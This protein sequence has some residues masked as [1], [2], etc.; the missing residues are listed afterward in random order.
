MLTPSKPVKSCE[1]GSPCGDCCGCTK[2]SI[3]LGNVD[4]T[5]DLNKPLSTAM[6]NALSG[7]VDLDTFTQLKN[8]VLALEN[9]MPDITDLEHRMDEAEDDILGLNAGYNSLHNTILSMADS[10]TDLGGRVTGVSDEL[11]TVGTR[12]DALEVAD[13][14]NVKID[15]AQDI[16]SRKTFTIPPIL[17]GNNAVYEALYLKNENMESNLIDENSG[18]NT[19]IAYIAKDNSLQARLRFRT[20][21][22]K[23]RQ[24]YIDIVDNVNTVKS[25]CIAQIIGNG[26]IYSPMLDAYAPMVRTSGN[27]LIY[28]DKQH[29]NGLMGQ[30]MVSNVPATGVYTFEVYFTGNVTQ[31]AKIDVF[32]YINNQSTVHYEFLMAWNGSASN[33][34]VYARHLGPSLASQNTPKFTVDNGVLKL[35][36]YGVNYHSIFINVT[37]ARSWTNS[38]TVNIARVESPDYS[39]LTLQNVI[40]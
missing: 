32:D 10:I 33:A 12:V 36:Y 31:F 19:I 38:M 1:C 34:K 17:K 39:G 27:Q 37:N 16:N 35:I 4:N 23:V 18:K 30:S 15:V 14:K 7:K 29:I 40:E 2:E 26:D 9:S 20:G 13:G 28:G 6:I 5:S 22:G 3:G 25:L 21:P 24:I 11:V 8:R